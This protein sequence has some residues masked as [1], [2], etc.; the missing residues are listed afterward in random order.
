MR[1]NFQPEPLQGRH[2]EPLQIQH[3]DPI[4]NELPTTPLSL[5]QLFLPLSIA[6]DW[7]AFTN[8]GQIPGP[9]SP[10]TRRSR[11]LQ[12]IATTAIEVYL[13]QSYFHRNGIKWGKF[14]N[15]LS[16]SLKKA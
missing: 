10:P 6:A 3:R 15:H 9:E 7:A 11:K 8:E 4:I 1:P 13:E 14:Q 2:F 12:W 16:F 5:F